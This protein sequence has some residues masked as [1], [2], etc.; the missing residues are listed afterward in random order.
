MCH[1]IAVFLSIEHTVLN[2]V[3]WDINQR[4]QNL[5]GIGN[6]IVNYKNFKT[7]GMLKACQDPILP[8]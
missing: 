7:P 2:M 6:V 3:L 8:R 5:I 4:L 1:L